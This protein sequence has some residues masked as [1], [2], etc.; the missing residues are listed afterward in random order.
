[1][2][3]VPYLIS[4][5]SFLKIAP[6]PCQLQR[7]FYTF[8]AC[9]HRQHHIISK[10]AGQTLCKYWKSVIIEGSRTE[11]KLFS[12]FRQCLHDL[13]M[14]MSLQQHLQFRSFHSIDGIRYGL[15]DQSTTYSIN[16]IEPF[17]CL[18]TVNDW[19]CIQRR[20]WCMQGMRRIGGLS[21]ITRNIFQAQTEDLL[22]KKRMNE[23]DYWL[24]INT[25]KNGTPNFYSSSYL[26]NSRISRE[27]VCIFVAFWIPDR[28]SFGLRKDNWNRVVTATQPRV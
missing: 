2:T 14:A 5:N 23:W 19:K 22:I 4:W 15:Y 11:S 8:C 3:R 18:M 10:H 12:L 28:W 27:E 24:L 13:G 21:N 17:L 9:I 25:K 1:M 16:I 7:C 20:S 6:L 26:I